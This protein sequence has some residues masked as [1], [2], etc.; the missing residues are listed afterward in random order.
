MLISKITVYIM[1]AFILGIVLFGL[2]KKIDVLGAFLDGAADGMKV[3]IKIMPTLC[4]L[5]A[6]IYMFRTSGALD[7][8]TS[9]LSPITSF[10]KI[11]SELIPL[12][13]LRPISGSGS[14][15]IVSDL[16]KTYGAD[17]LIGRA[18]SVIMGSTETTF[19]AIAVY[20][21]SVGIKNSRFTVKAA[22]IADLTGFLCG[23][24]FTRLLLK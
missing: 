22:L 3:T 21:G 9:F 23:L 6:A 18:A 24:W 19:Y 2:F 1:P 11:P 8:L 20:F 7:F 17:S 4:A 12:G 16:L 10:F 14:L 13:L 15:A 5:L